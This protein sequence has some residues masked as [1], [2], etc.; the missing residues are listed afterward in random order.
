[1]RLKEIT[2]QIE[3][4]DIF[5]SVV[6]RFF[7]YAVLIIMVLFMIFLD[8]PGAREWTMIELTELAFLLITA[9]I[10]ISAG[11]LDPSKRA[12][13]TSLAG[14]MILF[15]IRELDWIFYDIYLNWL[16]IA[17]I[18]I[19]FMTKLVIYQ[20]K[21]LNRALLD[22]FNQPCSGIVLSGFLTVLVFSRFCSNKLFWKLVM[23]HHFVNDVRRFAEEGVELFGY[24]LLLIA[25]IEY[26]N[27]CY[28]RAQQRK[29]RE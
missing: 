15:L 8:W 12:L 2:R 25:A 10:F 6:V 11:Y 19:Y 7:L 26:F 21:G 17:I 22:F 5:V 14:L 4:F 3:G 27:V 16:P 13:M 23:G 1:M 24:S 20:R 18:H 28:K 9:C 29:Q